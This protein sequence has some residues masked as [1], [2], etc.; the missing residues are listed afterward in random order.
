[1]LNPLSY[2]F[3]FNLTF[4]LSFQLAGNLD[5]C[6]ATGQSFITASAVLSLF[7]PPPSV[8]SVMNL[9]KS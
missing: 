8:I 5:A 2:L 7:H 3:V 6:G 9:S 1:M 4:L